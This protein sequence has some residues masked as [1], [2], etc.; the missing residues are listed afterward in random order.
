MTT[1]SRTALAVLPAVA[2]LLAGTA[3]SGPA[4]AVRPDSVTSEPSLTDRAF[5]AKLA[6]GDQGRSCSGALVDPYWVI[7]AASCFAEGATPVV[8]GA[9]KARTTVTV[10]RTDLD[11][12][13]GVV[14]EATELVPRTDRDLVLVRLARP[15]TG[16]TPVALTASAPSAGQQVTVAGFG[17]TRTEWAPRKLHGAVFTVGD[18]DA[19]GFP[20]AAPSPA[21]ATLCKGDAGA[22]AVRA[23]GGRFELLGITSRSWQGGC[24]GTPSAETRTGAYQARVDGLAQWVRDTTASVLGDADADGRADVAMT[25]FHAD[26]AVGFFTSTADRAGMLGAFNSTYTVPAASWDRASMKLVPGDFNGDHRSDLAMLYRFGD[27]SI[28]LFT[29]AA[30]PD[31]TI[32]QF[33]GPSYK[34]PASA[35]WNWNAIEVY[36]G[37]ANGDGRGDVLMAYHHTD[38]A[39]GFFTSLA[40]QAGNLS[41]FNSTFTVPAASWDRASMKLVPGDFN[42]DHRSDLAMLYRYGD[43]SIGLFTG[44]AKTDGTIGQFQGPSYKVP[45][46]A[47]WNW[48]AIEVYPGD[49]NGD[50][51]GDV[52]MAYHHTD[53]AIGF[54]TSLADQA[55]N[56]SQFNSTFT[57]PAASWDRAS[58]KLVPGDFNGDHRSDLAMLYRYGDGSIGLF[59]GLAKT[60]GTIGQFQGPSYKV[61]ASAGWSWNAVEVRR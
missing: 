20:V 12:T 58:M 24:L 32:G 6:V 31:G 33:Q 7:S 49:A 22:P 35:G 54:F 39:I 3:G 11:T 50:G 43:G 18:P 37:D 36:P 1:R 47:G 42:G 55:G 4:A 38:G 27:G 2:A 45:A 60:D 10:G 25:Y 16:V 34:V 5:T 59:T 14:T 57:V 40:D 15:A 48:N 28:G 8:A 13:T 9:P 41:Q 23:N 56:L 21:D 19:G 61:P 44:L 46:S 29:G 53:G 30:Q 26:G 17:R 52:L 51:R